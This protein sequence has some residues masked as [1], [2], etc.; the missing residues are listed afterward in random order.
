MAWDLGGGILR[1]WQDSSLSWE[2][3]AP[4]QL[5]SLG[6]ATDADA[7]NR[8]AV[9]APATLLS[10]AGA[11]HQLKINKASDAET[12]SLLF[13]SDWVGH[14]ELGLVGDN[15]LTLKVSV[16]GTDWNEVMRVDPAAVQLDVP[17]T[18]LAVQSDV[19]DTTSS[20]L[21][22]VGAFGLGGKDSS[23][24]CMADGTADLSSGFY[25]GK[26]SSAD[27]ATFPSSGCRYRPFLNITRRVSSGVYEQLRLFF[28]AETMYMREATDDGVWGGRLPF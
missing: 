3:A 19:I 7:I 25:S 28:D 2:V 5:Q 1:V 21:M 17:I 14:A 12:A 26:G 16:D 11:G 10:H 6:I 20:R 15:T 23:V 24:V 13:Q 27:L 8:F 9:S 4:T 22:A 18:G